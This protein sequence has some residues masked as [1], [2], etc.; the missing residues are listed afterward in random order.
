MTEEDSSKK[1]IPPPR[2]GAGPV[3]PTTTASAPDGK[4][5][6]TTSGLFDALQAAQDRKTASKPPPPATG[7][8][9]MQARPKL[10]IKRLVFFGTLAAVLTFM[11][12]G[13]IKLV[14]KAPTPPPL[15]NRQ[16]THPPDPP[17]AFKAPDPPKQSRIKT[18]H[19]KK[20]E[21]KPPPQ[22]RES[23]DSS[24]FSRSQPPGTTPDNNATPPPARSENDY[25]Q[26]SPYQPDAP[27]Q[28]PPP[29]DQPVPPQ[30]QD[31]EPPPPDKALDATPAQ[32]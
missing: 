13:L 18:P 4:I 11:V 6:D 19:R 29:Q 3:R 2:P 17:P 10:S 23:H 27:P 9:G 5:L 21:S 12:W 28:D 26:T 15:Q 1:F 24:A 20:T 7:E 25:N 31:P 8:W 16:N 30:S 22:R 14:A 32:Y